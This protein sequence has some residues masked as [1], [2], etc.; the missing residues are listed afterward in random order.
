R[1]AW[2]LHCGHPGARSSRRYRH[3]GTS[4]R[5]CGGASLSRLHRSKVPAPSSQPETVQ[6][7]EHAADSNGFP[8]WL[9]LGAGLLAL[10]TA[11]N[12]ELVR[13]MKSNAL[14]P[15]TDRLPDPLDI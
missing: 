12:V 6:A 9:A 10:G 7:R 3:R 4:R 15:A 11:V 13:M 14:D 2:A 8:R 5:A 1:E